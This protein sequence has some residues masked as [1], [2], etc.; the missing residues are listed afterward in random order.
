MAHQRLTFCTKPAHG[1]DGRGLPLILCFRVDAEREQPVDREG[2]ARECQHR[3]VVRR[4]VGQSRLAALQE[5]FDRRVVGEHQCFD[6][7]RPRP[8][9]Q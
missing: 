7:A 6:Q 5:P 8:A 1:F 4:V 9:C 2:R 3:A